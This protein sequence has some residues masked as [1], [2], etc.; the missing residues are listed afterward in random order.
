MWLFFLSSIYITLVF[1]LLFMKSPHRHI[2][3]DERFR[4]LFWIIWCIQWLN[5]WVG[6]RNYTTF[7]LLMVFVLLMVC[8]APFNYLDINLEI[9][10]SLKIYKKNFEDWFCRKYG[11]TSTRVTI[12][13]LWQFS[14]KSFDEITAQRLCPKFVTRYRHLHFVKK[15]WWISDNLL[16]FRKCVSIFSIDF[17]KQFHRSKPSEQPSHSCSDL[18]SNN[19]N[20]I[21]YSDKHIKFKII[22]IF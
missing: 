22:R 1:F 15:F 17:D 9:S 5:N 12:L 18:E 8:I 3:S 16:F 14:D 20:I 11:L 21:I 2:I 7:I 13:F 4:R 10:G 19:L 6:K